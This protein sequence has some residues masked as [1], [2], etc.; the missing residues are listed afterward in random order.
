M[1]RAWSFSLALLLGYLLTFQL[2]RVFADRAAFLLVGGM[3]VV[4]M[5]RGFERAAR[6]HYFANR[7]DLVMHGLVI[8]DV[9]LE[10]L[11]YEAF[12]TASQCFLC[13]PGD[14]ASL[15]SSYGFCWCAA[16]LSGLIG[17]YHWY[18]LKKSRR[19]NRDLGPTPGIAPLPGTLE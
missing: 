8:V 10:S 19:S 15:H 9:A 5:V 7:T 14:P 12:N 4:A 16:V 18:A 17:G 13:I 1:M 6:G 11:S 2:W 3:A